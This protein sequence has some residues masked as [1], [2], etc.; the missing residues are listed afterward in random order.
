MLRKLDQKTRKQIDVVIAKNRK[1]IEAIAGFADVEAGF[2][3]VNG[4]VKRVPA[5]ILFVERKKPEDSLLPGQMAPKTMGGF[6]V[7]VVEIGPSRALRLETGIDDGTAALAGGLTYQ[8]LDGNP[9]DQRFSVT[10]KMNCHVGPDQGWPVLKAFLQGTKRKLVAAIY[11]F[12]A[13]WVSK[14]LVETIN[15]GGTTSRKMVLTWDD[16]MTN[17]EPEIRTAFKQ[18][19]GQKLDAWIVQCGGSKRFASAYHEKVAVRDSSAFWLSSGNWSRRSMPN[20]DPITDPSSGSGMYSKSNREWHLTLSD[21]PLAKLFEKYI[22]YDRDKSEEENSA[23]G[24]RQPTVMP[25]LFVPIEAL[26]ADFDA[27]LAAPTPVPAQQLPLHGQAYDIQ[28]LLCPDNYIVRIT[29]WVASAKS[30]LYLQFSYITWTDRPNDKPFRDL[31]KSIAKLSYKANFDLK[32]IVGNGDAPEKVRKLVENGFNEACI[33]VQASIHNKAII[34]DSKAVLVSSANWSSDGTLRNRDAGLIIH[35]PEITAYYEAV[36]MDDWDKR[37]KAHLG[38]A[39]GVR[40]AADDA[41]TPPGMVRI[42][43]NDYFEE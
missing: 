43:W 37:A 20:I 22:K 31:L 32:I 11:D 2:P 39:T 38:S 9:I 16:H 4:W 1:K 15:G 10:A 19:L 13:E 27:A 5:I 28:P 6:P 36:F 33:R 7:D 25:D 18:A 35:D 23:L 30:S 17:G 29:E 14:T 24:T 34:V 8:L 3:I 21:K 42:G 41:P 26:S 12:N 40:I